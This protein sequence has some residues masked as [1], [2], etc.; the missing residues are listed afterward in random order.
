MNDR[1][2]RPNDFLRAIRKPAA[3]VP[4][5][6]K[7]FGMYEEMCIAFSDLHE[8]LDGLRS[9]YGQVG[10]SGQNLMSDLSKEYIAAVQRGDEEEAARIQAGIQELSK[11]F[12]EAV[13]DGALP[14]SPNGFSRTMWQEH[15]EAELFGRI[16][17]VIAGKSAQVPA[18]TG[19]KDFQGNV[20]AF[21][22]GYLDVVSELSKAIADE[23]SGDEVTTE[24]EL[25][26]F[27]RYLAIADS[28]TLRLSEE[29][30]I[31]N[32][33]ISNGYGRWM[34][35]SNKLRTAYGTIAHVRREYSS[36]L[37]TQRM[38]NA[39]VRSIIRSIE[40]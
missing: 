24:H 29:R 27:R 28:I 16:W 7:D 32:Y 5:P 20:Q 21:L 39:A 38:I 11:G 31:P 35:Y 23:L 17:P 37:S 30:H 13:Q 36:R 33:V 2:P 34:A 26:V 14:E 19:W 8:F 3:R 9:R 4:D 12:E 40:G 22:Y 10:Y 18:L 1:P 15:M 6:T 25:E